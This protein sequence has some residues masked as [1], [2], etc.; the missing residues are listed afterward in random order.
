MKILLT[1]F[2]QKWP[3]KAQKTQNDGNYD[4]LI[5]WNLCFLWPKFHRLKFVP[6]LSAHRRYELLTNFLVSGSGRDA[7]ATWRGHLARCLRPIVTAKFVPS[8]SAHRRRE[9]LLATLIAASPF[10]LAQAEAEYEAP[11][12]LQAS[13]MLPADQLQGPSHRVRDLVATDGYMGHFQIDSDFGTFEA[14]GVSQVKVRIAEINAMRTLVDTSK[15][16]LFAEGMKRS[17]EQPIDAVKNIVQ[18]PGTSIKKA[19]QTVGHFFRKVGDSVERG[20]KKLGADEA[21]GGG[22]NASDIG[23][24]ARNA[25]GFDKAKL[26]VAKQLG[27]DPYSDQPR[28]QEEMDKVTW[29]FFA[30]GL[31]LRIGAAAA[32]AGTA[33]VATKMVGIPEEIYALT[34]AEIALRDRDSLTA[35]GVIDADTDAFLLQPSLST[36]RR[37]RIVLALEALP[38]AA[39]RGRVVQLAN[40]CESAEHTEFLIASLSMLADRQRGGGAD[41]KEL[42]VHGRLLAATTA[43]GTIEVPAPVDHVTWIEPVAAFASRDDLAG[44]SKRLVHTGRLSEATTAGFTAA[45]WQTLAIAYP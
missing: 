3:Q 37:H 27:V 39:G 11:V 32:S 21:S 12:L 45:G 1:N 16:D 7:R 20:V 8:L 42:H 24:A 44:G 38:A 2:M 5:L 15:G 4:P 22:A 14:I 18:H 35:M 19:P 31:P 29:A 6:S 33:L 26:D 25:V 40:A 10:A 34:Q 41:Y 23:N 36:T 13:T 17:I 28:V 43:D 9:L 30:G